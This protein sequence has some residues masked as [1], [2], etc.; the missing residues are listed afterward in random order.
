MT[1]L[2]N[3]MEKFKIAMANPYAIKRYLQTQ[4]RVEED[5]KRKWAKL[6]TTST[7]KEKLLRLA[8]NK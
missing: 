5:I 7:Q 1:E 2:D 8:R 4:K 3:A 6:S